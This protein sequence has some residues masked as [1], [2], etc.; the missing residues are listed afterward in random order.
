M[1]IACSFVRAGRNESYEPRSRSWRFSPLYGTV[2]LLTSQ[3]AAK[4]KEFRSSRKISSNER[5]AILKTKPLAGPCL[6]NNSLCSDRGCDK[7]HHMAYLSSGADLVDEPTY[8]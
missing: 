2:G 4:F 8:R 5:I 1:S 3:F 6:A 7:R